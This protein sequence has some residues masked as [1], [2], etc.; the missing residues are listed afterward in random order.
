MSNMKPS[1][2]INLIHVSVVLAII[3]VTT[4]P[5]KVGS[6]SQPP[7][8]LFISASPQRIEAL[9]DEARRESEVVIRRRYATVNF[10]FFSS[11]V[12]AAESK[13]RAA[14]KVSLALFE[15][16]RVELDTTNVKR[17]DDGIYTW[18]S[19]VEA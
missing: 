17:Q 14:R 15:D 6:A 5:A 19:N 16:V 13:D 18:E 8:E 2:A 1:R 11:Q 12:L 3:A 4:L 9:P 7:D 10:D